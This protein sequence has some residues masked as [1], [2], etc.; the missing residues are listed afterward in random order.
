MLNLGYFSS[1]TTWEIIKIFFYGTWF[2]FS[3]I[4]ILNLFFVL[5]YL[6]PFPF[7]YSR[8]YKK[9]LDWI[10]IVSN[11]LILIFNFID[12]EY[13]KFIFKRSTFD[14]F[15]YIFLSNDAVE[16]LPQFLRDFW[17]IPLLWLAVCTGGMLVIFNVDFERKRLPNHRWPWV[18][19][20]V[21]E[22]CVILGLMFIGA[23]GLGLKPIQIIT[24]SRFT[25]TANF[26]LILNTPFSILHT[27]KDDGLKQV[28]YM[29]HEEAL[30]YLQTEK[31]YYKN[32]PTRKENVVIIMLESF[33]FPY[34]GS[35]SGQKTYTPF[36]DSLIG[37]SLM[38]DHAY[39]NGKKS[40]DALPSILASLPELIEEPYIISQYGGN[41][42][43][44]LPAILKQNGYHTSFFH[45]GRNGTFRFDDFSKA[46]GCS[47]YFG[48]SE[49]TGPYAY[50]G[51]WGI[52]DEEFLQF[53]ARKI[54]SFPKPFFSCMFTLSS[55]H[56][57]FLPE[58]YKDKFKGGELP[59]YKTIEYADYSLRKFF[60]T[61]KDK[62]WFKNTLFILTADHA[63]QEE[64]YTKY[65][66][67]DRY[68]IPIIFYLPADST[69]KGR[70]HEIIQQ[71]DIMPS[72]IDYLNIKGRYVCFGSSVFEP[73]ETRQSVQYLGGVYSMMNRG[74]CIQWDGTKVLA[75][76]PLDESLG[77]E[78]NSTNKTLI[79][80]QL[81]ATIQQYNDRLIN[82]KLTIKSSR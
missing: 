61:V 37:Q 5:L 27:M 78:N 67:A 51:D 57:Y 49:Y 14:L 82:N 10:F 50:D 72:V 76:E 60:E 2:D 77:T 22:L 4:A 52:Y 9:W 62:P 55:H 80:K 25:S 40:I 63:A 59:I 8:N 79:E 24:A 54:D 73:D 56:P 20:F 36:L 19:L 48:M 32:V 39:A 18:F 23:R 6:L 64:D 7:I 65:K 47:M 26:P 35:L 1:C 31:N 15:D 3:A 45:G 71:A 81:E 11:S 33:S 75:L 13:F 74:Y 53:F 34:V 69:L 42:L 28:A 70:N 16:L 66:Y 68:H 21:P 41:K 46:A 29:S 12:C 17:Y 44:G 58:K 30:Q 38:F 43:L